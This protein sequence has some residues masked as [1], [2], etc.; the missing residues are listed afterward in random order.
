LIGGY[1]FFRLAENLQINHAIEPVGSVFPPGTTF[2]SHD[3]FGTRNVFNGVDF[4]MVNEVRW[5]RLSVESLLK[6]AVGNM[7]Q[8][9]DISGY[10]STF[11]GQTTTSREGG[12][13]AL[14]TNIGHFNRDRLTFIPEAGLKFGLQVTPAIRATVGYSFTYVSRVM[15]PGHQLDLV[16]NPTQRSGTLV[17]PARPLP[18]LT[19][20]DVFLQGVTAGLEFRY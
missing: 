10:S 18:V 15:R 11:D 13:L 6:V 12:L 9:L 2:S 17:G 20:A 1:R 7:H 4:G 16:I 3:E 5:W 14:P 19:S 8:E